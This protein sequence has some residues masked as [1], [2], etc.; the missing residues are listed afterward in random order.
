MNTP[1][2]LN[3]EGRTAVPRPG[4]G[5]TR[6]RPDLEA[7]PPDDGGHQGSYTIPQDTLAEPGSD[8]GRAPSLHR[9]PALSPNRPGASLTMIA[10]IAVIATFLL[11]ILLA[12]FV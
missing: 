9:D 3:P 8:W 1:P 4:T 12:L 7:S 11:A 10:I 2:P 6:H 5:S